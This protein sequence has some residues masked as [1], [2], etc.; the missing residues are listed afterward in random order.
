MTNA[1]EVRDLTKAY[2]HNQAVDGLTFDVARGE[3]FAILGPNGAGKSTAVEILEGHRTRDGGSVSVL[4]VDPATGGR[5]FRDRIGIVLQAAGIDKELTVGEVLDL[6]GS[7]YSRRRPA[8]EVLA[9]VELVEKS[10]DRV[11]TL[12]GGQQRRVDL[13]LGL[14][15]DPE[16]I[17]LDEPTTGFD[18]AARRRSWELIEALASKGTTVV[19]TT[20]YLE[21]AEYLADRVAVMASGKIVASGTPDELRASA[22]AGTVIRFTLPAVD[23]ALAGLLDPLVG[24]ATGR[25]G[26]IEIVTA[27]PTADLAHVTAWAVS[28]GIELAGLSVESMNLEDVYLRLVGDEVVSS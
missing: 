27:K 7:A 15:G 23:A 25:D 14:I 22:D 28:H 13:A 16:L 17:F 10:D 21:E 8:D 20:H 12:S 2:A 24:N 3:I 6:Y 18:P 9:M 19:L 11:S 5:A 4:G 26:K 1:I